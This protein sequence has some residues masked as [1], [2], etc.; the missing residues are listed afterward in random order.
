MQKCE[1][2]KGHAMGEGNVAIPDEGKAAEDEG[3][4]ANP[5]E[6]KMAQSEGM[7]RKKARLLEG[8]MPR[9]RGCGLCAACVYR[10]EEECAGADMDEEDHCEALELAWVEAALT[11]GV[12]DICGCLV[13]EAGC[14]RCQIVWAPGRTVEAEGEDMVRGEGA[15]MAR[16][17]MV[18]VHEVLERNKA[19]IHEVVEAGEDMD[20]FLEPDTFEASSQTS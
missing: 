1:V 18:S 14:M 11:R 17:R 8:L 4:V 5:D 7:A 19:K 12:C 6:G 10:L 3:K 16:G 15:D 13:D 9:V 2:A 20:T